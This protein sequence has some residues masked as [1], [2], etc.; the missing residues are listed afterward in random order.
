MDWIS[1]NVEVSVTITQV[2]CLVATQVFKPKLKKLIFSLY[3]FHAPLTLLILLELMQLNLVQQLLIFFLRYN[4]C[5]IFSLLRRIGGLKSNHKVVKSLSETRW[6]IRRDAY[7]SL[8]ES[9]FE[10]LLVLKEISED[11]NE[12]PTI[13][14]EAMLVQ[15]FKLF[16]NVLLINLVE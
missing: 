16:G 10:I 11:S 2:T 6:S 15:F 3:T 13:R 9:W 5:I 7:E 1:K 8:S 14:V 12:N 4:L